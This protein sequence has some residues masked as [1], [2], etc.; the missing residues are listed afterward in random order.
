LQFIY[1]HS[2]SSSSSVQVS[3]IH[4]FPTPH[5][6]SCAEGRSTPPPNRSVATDDSICVNM[7]RFWKR[8]T[9]HGWRLSYSVFNNT[10]SWRMSGNF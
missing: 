5:L 7:Q 6:E 9:Y 1:Q 2:I 3:K 4:F 10:C 8:S